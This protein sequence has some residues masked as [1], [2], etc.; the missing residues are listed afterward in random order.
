M[1]SAI[2]ILFTAL[3]FACRADPSSGEW[4]PATG[5]SAELLRED[6]MNRSFVNPTRDKQGAGETEVIR[7]GDQQSFQFTVGSQ[8]TTSGQLVKVHRDFPEIW[9]L[10]LIMLN[11]PDL[12]GAHQ[13]FCAWSITL[14][15][16]SAQVTFQFN[17]N[18]IPGS[19]ATTEDY[20]NITTENNQVWTVLE[21]PVR[22]LQVKAAVLVGAAGPVNQT[23]QVAAFAAPRV[24]Q[25]APPDAD[26]A[27]KT[28][29]M[30][31]GFNAAPPR[32]R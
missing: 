9:D 25:P 15:V 18:I 28:E 27:G 4:I 31:P 30:P 7:W 12:A 2:L 5:N 3:L 8:Q 21:L 16:G 13:T 26:A 32:Y 20:G 24:F 23:V 11:T 1:R 10:Y 22:D 19:G 6:P 14:G 29:W 17:M